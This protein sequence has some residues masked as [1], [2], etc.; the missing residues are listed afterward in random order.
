ML[1]LRSCDAR[2]YWRV[3]VR[4]VRALR[5]YRLDRAARRR[6][7]TIG[8]SRGVSGRTL[9]VAADRFRLK[10]EHLFDECL[11]RAQLARCYLSE[12]LHEVGRLSGP[13][14]VASADARNRQ[15]G[16]L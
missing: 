13:Q 1:E 11:H 5:R 2:R 12:Y 4:P 8:D 14:A 16:N 6:R 7:R 9:A 3:G 15:P 10:R